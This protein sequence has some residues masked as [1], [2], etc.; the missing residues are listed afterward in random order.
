MDFPILSPDQVASA[1]TEQLLG[2][3]YILLLAFSG[4]VVCIVLVN[5][6]FRALFWFFDGWWSRRGAAN[7]RKD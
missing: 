2:S 4:M 7:G 5:W 6:I 3:I 1:S